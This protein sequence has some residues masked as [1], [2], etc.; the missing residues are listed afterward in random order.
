MTD[1]ARFRALLAEATPLPWVAQSRDDGVD[2]PWYIDTH[3]YP[4]GPEPVI[5]EG[6]RLSG[7][8]ATLIVE[9]VNALPGIL[10]ERD[11]LRAVVRA[12]IDETYFPHHTPS[13]ESG[14]E[15]WDVMLDVPTIE[16]CERALRAL[17][18]LDAAP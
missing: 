2:E 4:E 10:E 13:S 16:T 12:F 7:P 1:T 14:P 8:D 9:A 17:A 11:A 18:A 3:A 15:E 6:Y 5:A